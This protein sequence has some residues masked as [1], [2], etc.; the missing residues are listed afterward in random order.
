MGGGHGV[1]KAVGRESGLK[2]KEMEGGITW[3]MEDDVANA[4]QDIAGEGH[5]MLQAHTTSAVKTGV[6][7]SG[8]GTWRE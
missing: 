4:A 8:Y 1:G 2:G 5:V 7:C 6:R 3:S